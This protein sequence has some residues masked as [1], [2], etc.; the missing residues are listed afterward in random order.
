VKVFAAAV[1]AALVAAPGAA[2]AVDRGLA[3]PGLV[4]T[5]EA[6]GPEV[7]YAAAGRCVEVWVWDTADRGNRRH[8]RH[9]FE[10]TSTG[11]GVAAVAVAGRR[12]L[13]LAYTGGNTREWSLWTSSRTAPRPRLLRFVARDVDAEPPI[14]LGTAYAGALAYAV[15]RSVVALRPSGARLFAWEAPERVVAVAARRQGF[16]VMLA[17]GDVVTLSPAGTPV[18]RHAF[19]P[20]RPR[21][22]ALAAAGLVVHLDR[23]LLVRGAAGERVFPLPANARFLGLASGIAAY[24]SGGELRLLRLSDGADV[25]FRGLPQGFRAELDERGLAYGW[26]RRVSWVGLPQVVAAFR[27][28]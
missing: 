23:K 26:N 4:G 22:A 3:A 8:G 15:G 17:G 18:R 11:S 21:A 12:A 13:W 7:A 25:R 1:L 28:A 2:G 6:S 14:V 27:G 5:L 24:G 19:G 20:E 10:R 16:A 9:C